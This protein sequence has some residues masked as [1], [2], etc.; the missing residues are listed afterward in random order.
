[1]QLSRHYGYTLRYIFALVLVGAGTLYSLAELDLHIR[2][3]AAYISHV[4]EAVYQ[5]A[6][7]NRVAG[8]TNVLRH[9]HDH[10]QKQLAQARAQDALNKLIV[11]SDSARGNIL[12]LSR[13]RHSRDPDRALD[14]WLL[15][16]FAPHL[17]YREHADDIYFAG[18]QAL[19]RRIRN[20]ISMAEIF[21]ASPLPAERHEAAEYLGQYLK[22]DLN[23][24][25]RRV[26]LAL[27]LAGLA[28]FKLAALTVKI[29]AILSIVILVVLA[30]TVFRPLFRRVL[31]TEALLQQ[32]MEAAEAATLAKSRFLANMSHEV[33]TPL[34]GIVGVAEL[35]D[36][37][38]LPA[39]QKNLV[40]VLQSSCQ[41][42]LDIV[43]DILDIS[44][45]EAQRVTLES[46]PFDLR[47]M[48]NELHV[49]MKP[50][51]G[52]S[53]LQW[54][55]IY[56]N[57]LPSVFEGDPTRV[58]Q[59]LMNLLGNAFKFTATGFV[60]L[61]IT[62]RATDTSHYEITLQVEDSGIGIAPARISALFQKFTQADESTSRQYGGTGLG[63]TISKELVE[64]MGGSITVLSRPGHGSTFTVTL[65][66]PT[67]IL[68]ASHP[69]PQPVS[70]RHRHIL[71]VEDSETNQL[72]IT[73]LL[74]NQGCSVTAARNGHE[75]VQQIQKGV[76]FDLVLMDCQMPGMDGFAA[77][78]EIR[79]LPGGEA[80]PI[81]ALT[82]AAVDGERQRCL[83]AGMNDFLTKP[84]R[85]ADLQAALARYAPGDGGAFQQAL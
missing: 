31:Q 23:S 15:R 72:I 18:P 19:D 41:H 2:R 24:D 67:A 21:L 30:L 35:L 7:I 66:L 68:S 65:I 5:Y 50:R 63:L 76:G 6:L 60:R 43:N 9:F 80:L 79:H 82:A 69:P 61:K 47:T 52:E 58:R 3:G 53:G 44:K 48:C 45:L 20:F 12:D 42:L 1:M 10:E 4:D 27:Q 34:N 85:Q 51:A 49:L 28:E 56:D 84:V 83:N 62:G 74:E 71:L 46:I 39:H 16:S 36:Q 32:R 59:V 70:S 37:M 55:V 33:R 77:T 11:L 73:A 78:R 40:N 57:A 13:L 64:L 17:Y 22:I 14:N 75:A 29:Y 8:Q 26:A 81:I 38:P 25:A 54:D